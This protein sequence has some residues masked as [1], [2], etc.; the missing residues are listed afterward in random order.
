M[1][2]LSTIKRWLKRLFGIRTKPKEIGNLKYPSVPMTERRV[3]AARNQ[4]V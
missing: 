4:R 3:T 2:P 1:T